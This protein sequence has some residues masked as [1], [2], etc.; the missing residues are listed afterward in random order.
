MNGATKQITMAHANFNLQLL[1]ASDPPQECV[2][3]IVIAPPTGAFIV[4]ECLLPSGSAC[5]EET[6][7]I[8]PQQGDVKPK[9]TDP[10]ACS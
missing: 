10:H 5:Q 7:G 9:V 1:D 2:V 3:R 6:A 4:R 8:S